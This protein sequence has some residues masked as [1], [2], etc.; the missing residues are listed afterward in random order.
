MMSSGGRYI[1]LSHP[2]GRY[3]VSPRPV[4]LFNDPGGLADDDGDGAPGAEA[5]EEEAEAAGSVAGRG[6]GEESSRSGDRG[7]GGGPARI[8]LCDW[9]TRMTNEPMWAS[10]CGRFGCPAP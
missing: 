8:L 10:S 1:S 2:L 5:E 6:E 9:L 4:L 3:T 7:E